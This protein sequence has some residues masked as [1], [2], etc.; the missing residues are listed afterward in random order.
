MCNYHY[1]LHEFINLKYLCI[2]KTKTGFSVSI[3]FKFYKPKCY[4]KSAMNLPCLTVNKG[5]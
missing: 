3:F 2:N 5:V 1:T 4:L